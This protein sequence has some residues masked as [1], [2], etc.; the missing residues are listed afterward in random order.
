[1]R[2][3]LVYVGLL[4]V[5]VMSM[6]GCATVTN[7]ANSRQVNMVATIKGNQVQQTR[8]LNQMGLVTANARQGHALAE[9]SPKWGSYWTRL[10]LL[11]GPGKSEGEAVC[12]QKETYRARNKGIYAVRLDGV[13]ESGPIPA[14]TIKS[15]LEISIEVRSSEDN[16][17]V[18]RMHKII[19]AKEFTI[20]G[21]QLLW[22]STAEEQN[23]LTIGNGSRCSVSRANP[24]GSIYPK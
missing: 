9:F 3:S 4:S 5:V 20:D 1:M 6:V 18:E 15:E 7:V 11:L 13:V 16:S 23:P 2:S 21:H 24:A 10:A 8:R 19:K 17:V 14:N 12:E 22:M